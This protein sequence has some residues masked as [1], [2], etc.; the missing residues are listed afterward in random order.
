MTFA[1]AGRIAAAIISISPEVYCRIVHRCLRFV[2]I[3]GHINVLARVVAQPSADV[4]SHALQLHGQ[5]FECADPSLRHRLLERFEVVE[6]AARAPQ[7]QA[8]KIIHVLDVCH[9][10]QFKRR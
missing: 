1:P 4:A 3:S 10:Y 6:S 8:R 9:A 2:Q 7:A 5:Q